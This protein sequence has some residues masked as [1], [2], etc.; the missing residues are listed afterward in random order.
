MLASFEE[1]RRIL[2]ELLQIS[3]MP[4]TLFSYNKQP[5]E[6]DSLSTNENALTLLIEKTNYD[7]YNLLFNR[8]LSDSKS[9]GIGCLSALTDA[10]IFLQERANNGK[11]NH[12]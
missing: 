3:K 11:H 1:G 5:K 9:I 10:L 12:I 4:V 6:T 2:F 8:I 7:L